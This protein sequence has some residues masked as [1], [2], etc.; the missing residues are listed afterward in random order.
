MTA[1]TATRVVRGPVGDQQLTFAYVGE[2]AGLRYVQPYVQDSLFT[3]PPRILSDDHEAADCD[4]LL[5]TGPYDALRDREP[6]VILPFRVHLIA[7][8]GLGLRDLLSRNRRAAHRGQ[9]NRHGYT[10]RISTEVADLDRFYRHFY[11]PTMRRRHGPRARTV[12]LATA[13]EEIFAHGMLLQVCSGGEEVAGVVARLDRRPAVVHSRLIGVRDGAIRHWAN[14][15]AS[16]VD[17]FLLEWAA[18][19]GYA[20]VDLQ[21]AEPFLRKGSLQSKVA[22]GATLTTAPGPQSAEFIRL[23][24]GRD[25]PSIRGFLADHPIVTVDDD[26]RLGVTYFRDGERHPPLDLPVPKHGIHH[27][28]V[29]SLDAMLS[30]ERLVEYGTELAPR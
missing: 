11:L 6:A 16:V 22:L 10:Y 20:A 9:V 15:A 5:R 28:R 24:V 23:S 2:P 13:R 25:T 3:S 26:R 8:L 29:L 30:G 27:R 12:D 4:L 18:V 21:G 17:V 19:N 1:T 14:G 7:D